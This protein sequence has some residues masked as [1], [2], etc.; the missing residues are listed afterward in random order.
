M[1]NNFWE[2]KRVLVTGI[3]GFLGS[4]LAGELLKRG[5]EVTGLIR[6]EVTE[7]NFHVSGISKR[8]N[9]LHG[10][11][12]DFDV[13]S[14]AFLEYEIEFCLHVAAQ[15][16]VSIA[17][18]SPLSTFESNIKGTWILLEAARQYG[19]VKGVV[20]ASSDKAYGTQTMS[21][22]EEMPLLGENPYDVSKVCTDYLSRCYAQTYRMPVS[23]TRCSNLYGGGDLNFSRIIP[24]TIRSLLLDEAPIIRSDGSPLR[25]YLYI[26]DAVQGYLLL[27][28]HLA[29][30][31]FAGEAFNL[32]S[33][34]PVRVLDV[35]NRLIAV[36]GKNHL[37][38]LIQ[39]KGKMPGEIDSQFLNAD[40]AKKFLHWSPAVSLEEGLLETYSWYQ[41]FFETHKS[42]VI[43]GI[44]EGR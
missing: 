37:R 42:F 7:S 44:H 43:D 29:Q 10:S 41:K 3:T 8:V 5:A 19:K 22:R 1:T 40:K 18:Q 25:D 31:T 34:Q 14:R 38:P 15:A 21:Y 23:V 20:V 32:G 13:V 36:S 28:E 26:T 30:K 33:S 16:V 24:G 11:L 4:W 39:G 35:T 9:A 2:N 12:T 6:D 27:A 17:N